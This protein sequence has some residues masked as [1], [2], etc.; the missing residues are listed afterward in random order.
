MSDGIGHI[1]R[2]RYEQILAGDRDGIGQMGEIKFTIGDHALEIEPVRH[3]GGSRPADDREP[4]VDESLQIYADDLGITLST[5]RTYRFTAHRWPAERRRPG[6]SFNIHSILGYLS[7][8]AERFAAIDDPPYDSKAGRRRWTPDLAK[9]HVGNKPSR[10]V[11]TPQKVTAIHDLAQDDDVAA[12][13]AA[14][15]LRRPSVAK[16]VMTDDHARRMVNKAQTVKQKA[17][18]VHELTDDENV[19]A[20]VASDMLSRPE[21]A[22]RVVADDTARHMVNKAQTD[23]SRQQAET[24]RRED[25]VGQT[26]R[27]IE[28]TEEFLDLVSACHKFVSTCEKKVPQLRDR[29][30]SDHEQAV[31][32]QNIARVRAT[33]DWI[34]TAA[35]T[36]EVTM[37]DELTRLLRGE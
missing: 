13:I 3:V 5:I 26:V 22:S 7:D 30:L 10:P 34:E 32:A 33:L 25:P 1:S 8:E 9:I 31:L 17:E 16:K 27:K 23:R 11:T 18:I 19:A 20:Q 2:E 28:R 15:V 4:G 14:D 36:G 35:A 6:V 21:V 12:Q 29:H 24:F 37:D